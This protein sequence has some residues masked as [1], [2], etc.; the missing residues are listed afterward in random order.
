MWW[1]GARW[2][3]HLVQV[4]KISWLSWIRSHL[5][6]LL[7][8]C[9]SVDDNLSQTQWL[10]PNLACYANTNDRWDI[11]STPLT[12]GIC[13]ESIMPI[14]LFNMPKHFRSIFSNIIIEVYL[15]KH[16]KSISNALKFIKILT[17]N[18]E[19]FNIQQ[20]LNHNLL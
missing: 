13:S 11:P 12:F 5:M 10:Q 3:R 18:A 15:Y 2:S 19:I 4:P 17:I 20:F 8:I 7:E 14:T 16:E 9:E 6:W 1:A